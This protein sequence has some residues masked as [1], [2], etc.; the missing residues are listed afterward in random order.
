M[1]KSSDC[2]KFEDM[3][4]INQNLT[5]IEANKEFIKRDVDFKENQMRTLNLI[6]GDGVYSNVALLL[7]DQCPFII[8]V[9]TF[10]GI[11]QKIFKDRRE[12]SG[13]LFKQMNGVYE[14]IDNKNQIHSTIDG[15]YT[16]DRSDYPE[17]ALKEA[18]LNILVHRDYSFSASSLI[19]IYD[20]RIEFISIGGLLSGIEIEDVMAGLSICR[21]QKLANVFYRLRLIEAYG[22]GLNK[23]FT[24]YESTNKKPII[25]TTKNTFKIIL[26]NFNF[27]DEETGYIRERPIIYN[28]EEDIILKL[29][30]EKGYTT[31]L[32]IE[33]ALNTSGSTAYRSIKRLIDDGRIEKI[34]K[35]KNIKYVMKSNGAYKQ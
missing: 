8:K 27:M 13:S 11:D 29:I 35:A 19:N 2:D 32:A 1:I 25:S 24:A 28:T 18:L 14:H 10:Q 9:A 23:I 34:G 21:N 31:R 20:D 5:F 4:S 30:K 12:F 33:K 22:T 6:D 7:S 17:L 15:L 16:I 26:P 3:C